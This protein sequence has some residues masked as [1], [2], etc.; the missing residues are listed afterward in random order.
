[1]GNSKS[2][3]EE[4]LDNFVYKIQSNRNSL[5]QFYITNNFY[6]SIK[7]SLSHNTDMNIKNLAKQISSFCLSEKFFI[8]L[9]GEIKDKE[10]T[11]FS[12]FMIVFEHKEKFLSL[13][14]FFYLLDEI[15]NEKFKKQIKEF[16]NQFNNEPE[17]LEKSY[18]LYL[19][20]HNDFLDKMTNDYLRN[21]DFL[22][23][24]SKY[25]SAHVEDPT[26][27]FLYSLYLNI[28]SFLFHEELEGIN[29]INIIKNKN[30]LY[31]IY[32]NLQKCIPEKDDFDNIINVLNQIN[33]LNNCKGVFNIFLFILNLL[34]YNNEIS[35]KD[36]INERFFENYGERFDI[37]NRI[38]WTFYEESANKRYTKIILEGQI[39][40]KE[41]YYFNVFDEISKIKDNKI[42]DKISGCL[43]E[44]LFYD[45]T[46][47]LIKINCSQKNCLTLEK[48]E[49]AIK[50][51]KESCPIGYNDLDTY[52]QVG[53]KIINYTHSYN[54]FIR[55]LK[56]K[57]II[58]ENEKIY[59]ENKEKKL[60]D[61]NL[62]KNN[63]VIDIKKYDELKMELINE[64]EK[65]KNLEEKIKKL[66]KELEEKNE[67]SG[68]LNNVE[69]RKELD[70]EI[71]K[72]NNLKR[73]IEEEKE[74][75]MSLGKESKES[76]METLIE[77][78]K[79][80]KEL[81]IKLSRLPF[82]IEEGEEILSI[83]F[84]TSNQE[85]HYSIIC[86]NTDEFHKVESQLYKK[87]PKYS[88]NENFFL[89]NGNKINKYKTLK[90]NG[91]K[92]N[93]IIILNEIE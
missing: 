8:Y 77:K 25:L 73:Q 51:L 59:T 30:I 64:K 74:L 29:G 66:E 79:E 11:P 40:E 24:I 81:K 55:E 75:K 41:K 36:D 14:L 42:T 47:L 89:L 91:I 88:E 67:E 27:Y 13:K 87:F 38:I 49:N 10:E 15:Y 52:I 20:K 28:I 31:G 65:N 60:V 6:N 76:M 78:D 2:K 22:I 44:S 16:L 56:D 72:Y 21:S 1:M 34:K 93:D 35:S 71:Q 84:I 17:K 39:C 50:L 62:T 63:D 92:D 82:T 37:K 83:I 45:E 43:Y 86:K 7:S 5:L 19:K 48:I 70:I 61:N 32:E 68:G 53:S 4:L 33:S 23:E 54:L 46:I 57:K 80:I 69:L 26:L 9:V 58:E 12:D 85:L 3:S 90:Q 18:N